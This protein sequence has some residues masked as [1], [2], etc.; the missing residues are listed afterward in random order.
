MASRMHTHRLER[1]PSTMPLRR[2]APLRSWHGVP[3][4]TIVMGPNFSRSTTQSMMVM[5]P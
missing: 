4:D 1:V 2:P 3:P 5:S